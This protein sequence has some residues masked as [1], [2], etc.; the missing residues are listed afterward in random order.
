M[1]PRPTILSLLRDALAIALVAVL[2]VQALRRW[3]G[4]R[5][6]VP[7]DSMQPVLFGDPENGDVVFVDKLAR[8]ADCRRG[9][10]V[11]VR[12]ERQPDHQL[13]KR[14]A[15]S[16]DVVGEQWIEIKKG[17]V[18]LGES[19]QRLQRVVK[20]P[21]A[22]LTRAVPWGELPGTEDAAQVFDL[23]AATG[24]GP[25]QLPPMAELLAEARSSYR[26]RARRSRHR[27]PLTGVLPEGAVGSDRPIDCTFLDQHGVRSANGDD[28]P[29]IDCSMSLQV[30]EVPGTLLCTVDCSDG[31]TTFLWTPGTR[32]AAIW[33]DAR[34]GKSVE[35][36]PD[37]LATTIT[38]GRLD[39][40]D[41]LMLGDRTVL[42][43]PL[44]TQPRSPKP[45]TYL[46][47]AHVA[48]RPLTIRS[49]RVF[50]DV[51]AWRQ[52]ELGPVGQAGS[53]PRYVAPGEWFLLGDNAFDSRDSRQ[54]GPV[55][56]SDFLGVPRC[57]IG[58]WSR[59]RW[60]QP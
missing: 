4:D 38:F 12:D 6:L 16:G 33:S 29:V 15:A 44:R 52:P 23:R 20:E 5:Y 59:R 57:V 54:F 25:W 40:R 22:A 47:V 28:V 45:R 9:H 50:R 46:H 24:G 27:D 51:Y 13:V 11:V 39:G 55:A 1:H 14:I 19:A 41:Y 43:V 7:S 31:A 32:R 35:V 58:P 37:Q 17:D 30:D 60:I 42:V 21:A 36:P 53:W 48:D 18:W 8:A 49:M 56:K 2:T 34:A 10:L 3:C 26:P